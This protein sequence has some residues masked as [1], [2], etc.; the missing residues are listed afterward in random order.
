MN[1]DFK[2]AGNNQLTTAQ[3][4]Y[5]NALRA[6]INGEEAKTGHFLNAARNAV[7]PSGAHQSALKDPHFQDIRPDLTQR[8]F[9]GLYGDFG[10]GADKSPWVRHPYLLNM[11]GRHLEQ[12]GTNADREAFDAWC[13]THAKAFAEFADRYAD[14]MADLSAPKPALRIA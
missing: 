3:T 5:L 11:I 13:E 10:N 1:D 7:L 2:T 8:L 9:E 14:T 12:L 6:L 4:H